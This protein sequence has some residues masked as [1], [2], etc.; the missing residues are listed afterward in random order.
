LLF[1]S[2]SQSK[3]PGYILPAIPPAIFSVVSGLFDRSDET[4]ARR[5]FAI[6]TGL[7]LMLSAVAFAA[8]ES[9]VPNLGNLGSEL[10]HRIIYVSVFV[11]GMVSTVQG[12]KNRLASSLL[13]GA[14]TVLLALLGL[15]RGLHSVDPWY[16]ARYSAREAIRLYPAFQASDAAVDRQPRGVEFA[17][18][19][20][21]RREFPTWTDAATAR[22]VFTSRNRIPELKMAGFACPSYTF[23]QPIPAAVTCQRVPSFTGLGSGG[24][25]K[26]EK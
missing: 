8:F 19:F 2:F 17:L 14:L 20:Y 22:W 18:N 3:L 15:Y 1:F 4:R 24:Q 7:T 6:A 13:S 10:W 16:S 21:L 25:P 9:K 26:Q 23:G 12:W 11:G 5:I